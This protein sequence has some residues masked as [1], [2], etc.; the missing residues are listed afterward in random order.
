MTVTQMKNQTPQKRNDPGLRQ[1]AGMIEQVAK[2]QGCWLEVG[3]RPA[4]SSGH[5]FSWEWDDARG[6][7][8]I[9]RWDGVQWVAA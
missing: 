9:V 2:S 5:Y 8:L 6:G 1:V 7:Y 4:S 3:H